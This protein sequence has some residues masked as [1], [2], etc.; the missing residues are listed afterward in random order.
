MFFEARFVASLRM[1][2]QPP[3][4]GYTETETSKPEINF[5]IAD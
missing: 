4:T 5:P 1:A 3:V 2:D